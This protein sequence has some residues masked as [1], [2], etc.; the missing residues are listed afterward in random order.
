MAAGIATHF[1]K[2]FLDLKDIRQRNT[3]LE[4]GSLIAHFS[5][6]RQNWI[7]NL[8]TKRH[9]NDRRTSRSFH[10]SLCRMKSYMLAHGITGVSL[11]QIGCGLDKLNWKKVLTD[12]IHTFGHSG[13]CVTF[14]Y[15]NG[16]AIH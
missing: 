13:S 11:P 4:S 15:E 14:F 9:S 8:V 16:T 7:Y 6:Q 10:K 5:Y 2:L 3:F 12:I 1:L